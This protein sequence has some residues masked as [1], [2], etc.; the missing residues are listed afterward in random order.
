MYSII[1]FDLPQLEHW[2]QL[3]SEGI[4][5]PLV[6]LVYI[7]LSRSKCSTIVAL[8]GIIDSEIEKFLLNSVGYYQELNLKK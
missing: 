5:P 2:L 3:E 7:A 6:N 8:D 4:K 1:I